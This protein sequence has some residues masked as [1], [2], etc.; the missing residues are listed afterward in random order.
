MSDRGQQM[1]AWE[2][3]LIWSLSHCGKS[4]KRSPIKWK[5]GECGA[6]G[7]L[8]LVVLG[9]SA[10]VLHPTCRCAEYVGLTTQAQRD[11]NTGLQDFVYHNINRAMGWVSSLHW[12][13][14]KP[15]GQPAVCQDCLAA[16][17]HKE[18]K[19]HHD[20]PAKEDFQWAEGVGYR[21]NACRQHWQKHGC[22]R[23]ARLI[24]MDKWSQV[25]PKDREC[26]NCKCKADE[27]KGKIAAFLH[28]SPGPGW[29]CNACGLYYK[30]TG[31]LRPASARMR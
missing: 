8:G 5:H 14:A 29:Q 11:A 31:T 1:R 24:I 10:P 15:P 9:S 17:E 22:A 2:H 28:E 26:V 3:W 18:T 6:T 27:V 4:V 19:E 21:C 25:A 30:R 13:N 20:A 7:A 12:R 16:G 23:P